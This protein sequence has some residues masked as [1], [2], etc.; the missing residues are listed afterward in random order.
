MLDHSA[1]RA[2][3][4]LAQQRNVRARSGTLDSPRAMRRRL[5][6][7]PRD[8]AG[9]SGAISGAS[10]ES[11]AA[12]NAAGDSGADITKGARRHHTVSST[13]PRGAKQFGGH[14]LAYLMNQQEVPVRERLRAT[15]A[16]LTPTGQP[17]LQRTHFKR[18]PTL[19]RV[20]GRARACMQRRPLEFAS[21]SQRECFVL[22]A[23]GTLYVWEGASSLRVTRAFAHSM[24]I[25]ISDSEYGGRAT[26]EKVCG[27]HMSPHHAA[28]LN[29]LLHGDPADATTGDDGDDHPEGDAHSSVDAAVH[30]YLRECALYD[31]G[32][33]PVFIAAGRDLSRLQLVSAKA[34]VLVCPDEVYLWLG[35]RFGRSLQ[36]A[37]HSVA[38]TL[39]G[40]APL[41]V[42]REGLETVVFRHKFAHW[43]NVEK[44]YYSD[45][46]E[47]DVGE[48]ENDRRERDTAGA[49][50]TGAGTPT[51]KALASGA[52]TGG[53]RVS[54][55]AVGADEGADAKKSSR[56]VSAGREKRGGRKGS[57]FRRRSERS[58]F[59]T[60][61]ELLD[62]IHFGRL[63]EDVDPM[64]PQHA[65]ARKDFIKCFDMTPADFASA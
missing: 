38:D 35:S 59:Y 26:I 50:R 27:D 61:D 52:R 8:R 42:E 23:V 37:A 10:G 62:M 65:L 49:T 4:H 21:F 46:D 44:Q 41:F 51:Q 22:D 7:Q 19:Y 54:R 40:D 16:R 5:N 28:A 43:A 64:A 13:K 11:N 58:Q 6:Q 31:V 34:F 25:D 57:K 24:A 15:G 12:D 53:V 55:E 3:I 29:E 63:P 47:E 14:S 9:R 56:P 1:Q 20:F 17:E 33:S 60:L 45:E 2:R 18:T 32:G 48:E 30:A 39:R 36:S